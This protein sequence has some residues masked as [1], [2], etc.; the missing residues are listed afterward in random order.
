MFIVELRYVKLQKLTSSAFL[1]V[2]ILSHK[3]SFTMF[4]RKHLYRVSQQYSFIGWL[5]DTV[6]EDLCVLPAQEKTAVPRNR[7]RLVTSFSC[8]DLSPNNQLYMMPYFCIC[9]TM[10]SDSITDI[11]LVSCSTDIR[12]IVIL[13]ARKRGITKRGRFS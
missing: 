8:H 13:P 10:N 12:K 9:T 4:S 5:Q 1:F 2:Q 3:S 6:V 7:L 11:A